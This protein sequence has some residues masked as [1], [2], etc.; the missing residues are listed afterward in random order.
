MVLFTKEYILQHPSE[1]L[2]SLSVKVLRASVLLQGAERFG[3]AQTPVGARC[4]ED[5]ESAKRGAPGIIDRGD[6]ID[7]SGAAWRQQRC[8]T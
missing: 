6:Q 8:S 5:H 4:Q 3:A 2:F 1:Q 7:T